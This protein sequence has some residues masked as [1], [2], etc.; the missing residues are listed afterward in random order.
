VLGVFG[1]PNE[2]PKW[3]VG[4]TWRWQ[5]SDRH[6]TGHDEDVDRATEHSEVIN[7][8]HQ[9]ELTIRRNFNNRWSLSVGIP[10]LMATRSN[11]LR[12]QDPAGSGEVIGRTET[13]ARGLGDITVV[14]HFVIWDPVKHQRGN[15]V[16]GLGVK[17]PT[18]ENN[19]IDTRQRVTWDA[20]NMVNV[21][22][23]DTPRTVDQSIQPGDGGFGY[24]VDANGYWRFWRNQA[25]LY[26][27]GSYLINPG[28]I[29][30]VA[31]YRNNPGET[32]MSI[33]DAYLARWGAIY[34]PGHGLGLSLGMRI[35]GVPTYDLI[36]ES[37]GFRR[38]GYSLA[39]DPGAHWTHGPHTIAINIPWATHRNRKK[40]TA[41]HM[42]GTHGDAAFADYV[43][44]LG[45][46]YRF[47]AAA[48]RQESVVAPAAATNP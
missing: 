33:A 45:Y 32:I 10:Y 14:P 38:P 5:K 3:E 17:I 30:G 21:I 22:S 16:V 46:F 47:P 44:L 9:P 42:N 18:G 28:N 6:F 41:D 7:R 39:V 25:A 19:V 27:G 34:Y 24:V 26:A 2:V 36:G 20:T 1:D 8:I 31:T 29:S 13:Q 35:E 37:D 23:N 48:P 40:S 15:V 4:F 43:L 12:D 11:A